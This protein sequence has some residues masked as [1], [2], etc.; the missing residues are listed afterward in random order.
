M[1]LDDHARRAVHHLLTT[2]IS[3]GAE[4]GEFGPYTI[5]HG[6]TTLEDAVFGNFRADGDVSIWSSGVWLLSIRN[7][8]LVVWTLF[9]GTDKDS[10]VATLRAANELLGIDA[11]LDIVHERAH[12]GFITIAGPLTLAAYR[13]TQTTTVG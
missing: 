1:T 2:D 9:G 4:R 7:R 8:E 10:A 11:P 13:A 12:A 6:P 3:A 5:T